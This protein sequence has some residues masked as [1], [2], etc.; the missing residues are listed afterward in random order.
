[1]VT[2]VEIGSKKI[3]VATYNPTDA[4]AHLYCIYAAARIKEMLSTVSEKEA[5]KW[6][7]KHVPDSGEFLDSVEQGVA[8]RPLVPYGQFP[9]TPGDEKIE[10]EIVGHLRKTLSL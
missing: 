5:H 2:S 9:L 8:P 3:W 4:L 1:M 10:L 7:R 6:L